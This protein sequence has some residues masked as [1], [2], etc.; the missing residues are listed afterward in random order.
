MRRYQARIFNFARTLT[1]NDADAEDVTQETF[2]RAFRGIGRFRGD[3]RFGHWL[4]RIAANAARS[5]LRRRARLAPLWDRR[6]EAGDV[7]HGH[8]VGRADGV[9]E[10]LVRRDVLDRALAALPD[11]LREVLVLR[12]VEGLEYRAIAQI[13]DI[14]VGTVMSRLF[15]ARQRLR[16][17]LAHLL[18]GSGAAAPAGT[19][20]PLATAALK[21]IA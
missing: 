18:A 2:I 19:A 7:P 15:R 11:T 17:M 21:G 6:V 12:D 3:A 13:L 10:A 14:P 5:H 9:E 1:A 20:Q 4:Y 16:P 8:A